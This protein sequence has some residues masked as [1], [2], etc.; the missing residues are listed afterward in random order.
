MKRFSEEFKQR[1]AVVLCAVMLTPL[2]AVLYGQGQAPP[3]PP[4]GQALTP[5]QLHPDRIQLNLR[6]CECDRRFDRS[7]VYEPLALSIFHLLDF[8]PPSSMRAKAAPFVLV[9]G[10]VASLRA[11]RQRRFVNPSVTAF[12]SANCA[13]EKRPR[14]TAR[15]T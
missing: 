15:P 9:G 7:T 1:M 8:L 11:A 13:A 10:G 5:D 4:P 12:S 14:S 3:P 2:N 6:R